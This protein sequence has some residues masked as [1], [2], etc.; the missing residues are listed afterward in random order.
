MTGLGSAEGQF[1]VRSLRKSGRSRTNT[2]STGTRTG[3]GTSTNTPTHGGTNTEHQIEQSRQSTQHNRRRKKRG[4]EGLQVLRHVHM[5]EQFVCAYVSLRV[6]GY[7]NG[8][9][10]VFIL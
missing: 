1:R 2:S 5:W 3:T 10:A 6:L 8:C 7:M 4:V 9:L